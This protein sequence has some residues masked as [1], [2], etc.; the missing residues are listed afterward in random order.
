MRA[1]ARIALQRFG[2]RV[3]EA[4]DAE[5]ALDLL[6]DQPETRIDLLVTDL[7]LPGMDGRVLASHVRDQRPK[8]RVLFMSGY[9]DRLGTRTGFLEPGFE[10]LEKPFA[11]Q[12]LLTRTRQLIES[13]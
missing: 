3:I 7:V 10:L 12:T 5:A 4:R 1:F 13:V 8:T 2:Y 9:A 6:A 11:A